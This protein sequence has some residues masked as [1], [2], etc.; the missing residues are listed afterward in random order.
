M[1]GYLGYFGGFG[2]RNADKQGANKNITTAFH[3]PYGFLL[4]LD[5][6]LVPPHRGGTRKPG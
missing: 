3:P 6:F 5:F 2:G 4:E 1:V